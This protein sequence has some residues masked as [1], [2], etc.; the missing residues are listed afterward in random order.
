MDDAFG[1][2]GV[3]CA[4]YLYGYVEEF[5]YGHWLAVDAAA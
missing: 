5:V 1:V 3:E 2:R 4:G